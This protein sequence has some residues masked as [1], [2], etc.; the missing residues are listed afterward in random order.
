MTT[1]ATAIW[2]PT[3]SANPVP[4]VVYLNSFNDCKLDQD[5]TPGPTCYVWEDNSNTS[6]SQNGFG[7]LDLNIDPNQPSGQGDY[8]WNSKANA[9]FKIAISFCS[10]DV[11]E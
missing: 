11:C 3:G 8:G 6:G 5:P 9:K 10:L 1:K 4:L 2:G 7:F